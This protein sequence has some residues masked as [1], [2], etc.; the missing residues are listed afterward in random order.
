[1]NCDNA[2]LWLI[3]IGLLQLEA[4]LS[5]NNINDQKNINSIVDFMHANHITD[6]KSLEYKILKKFIAFAIKELDIQNKESLIPV[7]RRYHNFKDFVNFPKLGGPLL[8]YPEFQPIPHPMLEG[9]KSMLSVIRDQDVL[10]HY[11]FHSFNYVIDLLREAA[12][13]PK[14]ESIKIALYRVAKQSN[15][16][17]ALINA[18][19]NGKSVVVVCQSGI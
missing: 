14:V 7:R 8:S 18:I 6:H 3:V 1:M 9:S 10:L 2:T 12:I 13:D 16:V 17:N 19:R 5:F 4:Y 15:I 11:P